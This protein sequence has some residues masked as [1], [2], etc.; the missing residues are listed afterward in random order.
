MD[1]F[2]SVAML[3]LVHEGLRRQGIAA[4][5]APA[6][7]LGLVALA[8]K[9]SRL[10]AL[11][12]AH[13]PGVVARLGEAVNGLGDDP[14]LTAFSPA[15]D[16]LDLLERWQ[17]LER[18]VH[19]RHRVRIDQHG[20]QH[21]KWRHA[22][23]QRGAPPTP[24]EDLLV[25]GLLLVLAQHIGLRGLRARVAGTRAWL[26]EDGWR[27]GTWPARFDAWEWQWQAQAP[28][29]ARAGAVAA[30]RPGT[31][32]LTLLQAD[33]A[34][35]WTLARLADALQ[36][37]PRTLQRRLARDGQGFN[38]LLAQAR[39]NCAAHQLTSGDSSL[40]EVG[41]LSGYAD[42]PHFTR[43]FRAHTGLTPAMYRAQFG[44]PAARTQRTAE[45]T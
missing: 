21:L 11:W 20:P 9:R 17:R 28:D 40:A 13:G 44:E 22:S 7:R 3:R 18:F 26:F 2:A 23:L 5:P 24:A 15:T 38:H 10:D 14:M 31:T 45:R 25:A 39:L 41:Y 35:G 4:P 1:D 16:A 8:E 30:A 34:R 29:R 42:Q 43:Q 37:A 27:G 33:P 6:A 19:S 12:R 32:P 36:T